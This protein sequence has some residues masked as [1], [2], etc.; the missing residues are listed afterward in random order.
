MLTRTSVLNLIK[1]GY[2]AAAAAQYPADHAK[3]ACEAA[4]NALKGE[5]ASVG[6]KIP[7]YTIVDATNVSQMAKTLW[8]KDL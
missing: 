1:E 7:P 6:F 4:I 8:D 3:I 5:P 2:V